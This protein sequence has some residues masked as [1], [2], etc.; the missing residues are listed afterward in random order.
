MDAGKAS[1]KTFAWRKGGP[2]RQIA[3]L[4]GGATRALQVAGLEQPVDEHKGAHLLTWRYESHEAV[5]QAIAR[6]KAETGRVVHGSLHSQGAGPQER[7]RREADS[8]S[9][10]LDLK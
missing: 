1:G 3:H 4:I 9:D 7:D 6:I 2:M 8:L 10:V 5:I